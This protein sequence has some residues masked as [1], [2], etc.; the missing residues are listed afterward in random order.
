MAAVL[1][2]YAPLRLN[3]GACDRGFPG[4]L[5]V[6]ICPPADFVTDLAQPWPWDDSSVDEVKAYDVIEHIADRVHF[7]NELH[8]VLR[9]G[10]RAEIITPNATKGVG[11]ACD[12][13]HKSQWCLSSFKYFE[14]G[15]FAHTRLSRA[16]GITAA[17]RMLSVSES[18]CSGEDS[19]ERV[20]KI[21]AVMEAVK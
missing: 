20:W 14:S 19:R 16:Y 7:M 17:F 8:R 5:S 18:V 10:A 1:G 2:N 6:D 9:P 12:P 4:F 21:T 15:A 13:T 11:F 3:L